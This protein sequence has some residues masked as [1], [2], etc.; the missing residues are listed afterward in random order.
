[1]LKK[2]YNCLLC[3]CEKETAI[4]Q[5]ETF[6]PRVAIDI[7]SQRGTRPT[8]GRTWLSVPAYGAASRTGAGLPRALSGTGEN[9]SGAGHLSFPGAGRALPTAG[10]ETPRVAGS[11]GDCG[12]RT[13][14]PPTGN[15]PTRSHPDLS[16]PLSCLCH[17]SNLKAAASSIKAMNWRLFIIRK[18]DERIAVFSYDAT[19]G[20]IE[21][22]DY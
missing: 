12:S 16:L 15:Q 8:G 10:Q 19:F 18:A 14:M 21:R 4:H 6:L 22:T 17:A 9:A 5:K 13:A 11:A 2:N 7:R 1:M 3:Y 20:A